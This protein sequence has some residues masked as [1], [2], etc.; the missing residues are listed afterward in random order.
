[1]RRLQSILLPVDFSDTA[2]AIVPDVREIARRF[3]ARLTLVHAF[4]LAPA[5]AT[6]VHAHAG[7]PA[8]PLPYTAE[9][10]KTRGERHRHLLALTETICAGIPHAACIEDGDPA[11]VVESVAQRENADLIV[12]PTHGHGTFRRLVLGSVTAKVLHDTNYPVLT[13][14]HR[15]G[16]L[17]NADG[18]FHS[19]VCAVEMNRE[20]HDILDIGGMFAHEYGARICVVHI[21]A[22]P[23]AEAVGRMVRRALSPYG[24]L[25]D[26]A[27][28]RLLDST[29]PG[30]VRRT[31]ME[32]GADLLVVG[33]GHESGT[34]SRLWSPLYTLIRESPCPVLSV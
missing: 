27:L 31:A 1:M 29:V 23:S 20:A 24:G 10:Q 13:T 15:G 34:L 4:D 8:P 32:Q 21:E 30:G 5:Y 9:L 26:R 3:D 18:A 2:M 25:A 11:T 28:V 14:A 16:A 6:P 22:N 17:L 7:S 12:M 33:R 19:V